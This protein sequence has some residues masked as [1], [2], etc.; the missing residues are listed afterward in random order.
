MAKLQV[1]PKVLLQE[2]QP[3][4]LYSQNKGHK[5]QKTMIDCGIFALQHHG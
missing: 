4:G 5:K 2:T 1:I 3:Y